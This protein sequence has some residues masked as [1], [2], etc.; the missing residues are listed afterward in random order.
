MEKKENRRKA[1]QTS[2]TFSNKTRDSP[3]QILGAKG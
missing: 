3:N 2:I 1:G